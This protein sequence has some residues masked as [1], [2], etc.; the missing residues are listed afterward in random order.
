MQVGEIDVTPIGAESLGVRSLCTLV[1]TPD[2]TLLLDPSAALARRYKLEPHPSEY[3]QLMEILKL[4]RRASR[5]ADFLSIS[6]YH[7]DHVRPGFKN[8]VYN[9][10]SKGERKEMFTGKRILAKDNRDKINPSQ[11]RRG[12]YFEKD[13]G[14]V[15]KEVD[16]VDGKTME[17]GRTRLVFSHPLPHGPKA[18]P[19]GFVLSTLV[20]HEGVRFLYAPDVQ[21][22]VCRESLAYFLDLRPDVAIVGGP[23][24]YLSKFSEQDEQAALY[25]LTQLATVTPTLIVDH[26]NMRDEHWQIWI[27]PVRAAGERAGNLVLTM[28]EASGVPPNP[29]EAERKRLYEENPP[30]EEFMAWCDASQEFKMDNLPP[31]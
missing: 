5:E 27:S 30:S 10:S 11:R 29:L 3:R 24:T 20:E 28:A 7:F 2:L 8:C 19:M 12:Y 21:G 16:W 31:L 17:L 23:P 15:A 22:P 26:H 4:I 25:S 13:V 14:E 6:H 1:K 18:S 9:L